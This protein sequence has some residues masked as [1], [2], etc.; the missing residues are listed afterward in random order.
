MADRESTDVAGVVG[1]VRTKAMIEME[2][3]DPDPEQPS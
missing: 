3:L 2:D 1:R